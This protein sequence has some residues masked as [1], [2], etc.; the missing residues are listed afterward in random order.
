MFNN[1]KIVEHQ[2]LGIHWLLTVD[3]P[4]LF[5][6]MR[7][8]KTAT[9]IKYIKLKSSVKNILVVGPF[10]VL[11]GWIDD[12]SA[13]NENNIVFITGDNAKRRR[14]L[15]EVLK[16]KSS[17]QRQWIVTN[18][19]IHLSVPEIGLMPWDAVIL[20]E[21]RFIANPK[22]KV[23]KFYLRNFR[24]A[25]LRVCLSGTAA[26]E[27]DL[28]YFTQIQFLDHRHWQEKTF[29]EFRAKHFE[30]KNFD[31]VMKP[32]SEPY[33]NGVLNHCC[34]FLRRSQVKLGGVKVYE[35][36]AVELP[37]DI[38]TIYEKVQ[39]QFVLEYENEKLKTIWATGKY[40]WLRQLCS[41]IVGNKLISNH[42]LKLL[43][44]VLSELKDKPVVIW[45]SY[46]LELQ[47]IVE[48]LRQKQTGRVEQICGKIA[49][50]KR[51][52]YRKLFQQGKILYLVIQPQ[53]FKFGTNLSRAEALLYFSSPESGETRQ[54]TEDRTIDIALSDSIL[55][56]DLYCLDSIEEDIY[57]SNIRKESRQ[58]RMNRIMNRIGLKTYVA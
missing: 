57:M 43:W 33:I 20:D 32:E 26:T 54:Q 38:K 45:A 6:E 40:L 12:L 37:K 31:W 4:A 25:K 17:S 47:F 36:R 13:E 24:K 21:S 44:E 28:E 19:E 15:E 30:P 7:L 5:W 52:E 8:R 53:S 50:T 55:I 23:T 3:N 27:N 39:D 34:F 51:E 56:I 46:L 11:P 42:K 35:R 49:P 16:R 2:K 1:R 10:S 41:G 58:A 14:A 29:W 22:S 9:T 18:K 48:Y